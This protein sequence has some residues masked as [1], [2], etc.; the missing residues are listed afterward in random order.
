MGNTMR[1]QETAQNYS[2]SW[3]QQAIYQL[4]LIKAPN[5]W[6]NLLYPIL[7]ILWTE[8][9]LKLLDTYPN[10]NMYCIVK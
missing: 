8:L 3:K 6:L 4:N 2:N 9:L 1:K 7:I 10:F 5:N